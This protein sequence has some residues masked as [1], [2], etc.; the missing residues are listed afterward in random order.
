MHECKDILDDAS[1]QNPMQ[2]ISQ[3]H[4]SSFVRYWKGFTEYGNVNGEERTRKTEVY[5][6][7]GKTGTGKSFAAKALMD[8]KA[9][10]W[11][12]ACSKWWDGLGKW[13]KLVILD[14]FEGWVEYPIFLELMDENP[15]KLEIKGGQA[16]FMAEKL[17][18]TSNVLPSAWYSARENLDAFKRRVDHW[19][20]CNAIDD[21][22]DFE[23]DWKAFAQ[24]HVDMQMEGTIVYDF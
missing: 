13:H 22:I 12:Q 16:P 21:H 5:V 18:F 14:E 4:F 10:Y 6:F 11:K 3:S 20:Y 24:H 17:A 9:T 8:P 19:I 2:S 15:L 23:K 7:Y 1:V